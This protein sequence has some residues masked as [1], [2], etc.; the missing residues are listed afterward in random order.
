MKIQ[1]ISNLIVESRCSLNYHQKQPKAFLSL[2]ESELSPT[3]ERLPVHSFS[4]R[5]ISL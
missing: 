2:E 1:V 3:A 5:D 4:D